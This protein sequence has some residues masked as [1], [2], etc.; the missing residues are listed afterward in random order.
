MRLNEPRIS[1][2]RESDM[3]PEL[4]ALLGPR[5]KAIP[6]L[7]IFERSHTLPKRLKDSWLGVAIFCQRPTV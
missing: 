5:F 2:L 7:N 1:P 4:L 3:A 6:V